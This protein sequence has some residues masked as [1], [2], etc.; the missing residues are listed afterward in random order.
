M[1]MNIKFLPLKNNLEIAASENN[2]N[3]ESLRKK[4]EEG[5]NQR[6]GKF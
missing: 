1:L 4:Y 2:L 5:I 6:K 3:E